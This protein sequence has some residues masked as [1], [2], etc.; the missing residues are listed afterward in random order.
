MSLLEKLAVSLV[1][2]GLP[3]EAECIGKPFAFEWRDHLGF[4][5]LAIGRID[6]ISLTIDD[7]EKGTDK[8]IPFALVC[9]GIKRRRERAASPPHIYFARGVWHI[10][11]AD[12]EPLEQ[13]SQTPVIFD[14][15]LVLL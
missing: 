1:R 14:G 13:S 12:L 11:F 5:H 10:Y 3:R 9:S 15:D 4:E 2:A 7:H 6:G 8:E